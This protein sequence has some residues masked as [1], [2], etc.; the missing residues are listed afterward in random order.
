MA[1]V[2]AGVSAAGRAVTA[3]FY[4]AVVQFVFGVEQVDFAV[5]GVEVSVAAVSGR[6]F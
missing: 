3:F 4:G 5:V 6:L 1:D 2:G